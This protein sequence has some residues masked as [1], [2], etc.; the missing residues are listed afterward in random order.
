MY[1]SKISIQ[2]FR[3]LTLKIDSINTVS[4]LIGQNDCGK[5]NVCNAIMKV[6]DYK[7]RRIPFLKSDATN[8]NKEDII[9]EIELNVDGLS[10]EQL[11]IVG[12]YIHERDKTKYIIA[13]LVSNYNENTMEYED[14]LYYGDP[15]GD[16]QE[17]KINRET[18]LDEVLSIV[19]IN[20]KYDLEDS[21][22]VYF[23]SVEKTNKDKGICFGEDITNSIK[24]LNDTIQKDPIIESMEKEV[25]N[26]K[27]FDKLFENVE[28]GI[29]ANIKD[30]NVYSSLTVIPFDTNKNELENIG[31][32]KNKILTAILKSKIS[33]DIKQKI[34][35]VEEPENHLFVLHQRTYISA[36]LDLKPDQLIFTTHSPFTIDF[37]KVNQIIKIKNNF[38]M[39]EVFTFNNEFTDDFKSF[40]YLI[41]VEI[42]EMIFYDRVLL[43]EGSSEKYF[44]NNLI[45]ND[46]DFLNRLLEQKIGIC[47]IDGI[48]FKT[49]KRLLE[50]LGILVY[51]KTDNDIF[52]VQNEEN[53][54]RYAGI[55]RCIDLL[56]DVEKEQLFKIVKLDDDTLKFIG[57]ETGNDVVEKN[58]AEICEFFSKHRILL[59]RHKDGFEGDFKEFLQLTN[60]KLVTNGL[61]EEL[62]EAKLKNL[63]TFFVNNKI[64]L[65]VNDKNKKSILVNF[66]YE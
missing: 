58:M 29:K 46:I 1:I 15:K 14:T 56:S 4:M 37:E 54:Y 43:I 31:D 9:I 2:N 42:S 18:K 6:L 7:K 11:G 65:N 53:T 23:H 10:K 22:K 26:R 17:I 51:I 20:P 50:K 13:K 38:G 5:T 21:Q 63:H 19:Y 64:K 36:L 55:K 59:S 24:K 34:Y 25:N 49:T 47:E 40:G 35:I 52:K 44:Y 62:K 57:K 66:I 30:S 39:R 41:N 33:A 8:S 48:A 12:E 3:G 32:G 45:I 60:P 27:S 61:I 16:Y 28:F